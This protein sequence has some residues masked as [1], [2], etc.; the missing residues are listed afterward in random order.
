MANEIE[1]RLRGEDAPVHDGVAAYFD[2]VERECRKAGVP[3][4]DG[5]PENGVL[6][7]RDDPED[8]GSTIWVYVHNVELRGA[9]RLHG[10]ASLSNDVLCNGGEK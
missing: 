9:S 3:F 10:E 5:E 2:W 4:S 8:F 6:F 1:V 7:R